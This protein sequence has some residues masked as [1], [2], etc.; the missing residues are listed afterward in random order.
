[1]ILIDLILY[2]YYTNHIDNPPFD[3]FFSTNITIIC[4]TIDIGLVMTSMKHRGVFM[5]T[6][7][8]IGKI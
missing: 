8:D 6:Y 3:N 2:T 1:M 5:N 4:Q 7:R